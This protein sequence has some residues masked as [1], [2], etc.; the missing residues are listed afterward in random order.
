MLCSTRCKKRIARLSKLVLVLLWSCLPCWADDV[1]VAPIEPGGWQSW[2]ESITLGNERIEVVIVPALGRMTSFSAQGEDNMLRFIEHPETNVWFDA[3]SDRLYPV[4]QVDW[5]KL[6]EGKWPPPSDLDPGAWNARAWR[7][8]NGSQHCVLEV[9][10]GAPLHLACKRSF[11]LAPDQTG[12]RIKQRITRLEA[13]AV[14]VTLWNLTQ[15]N[16]AERVVL[17]LARKSNFGEGIRTVFG[18]TPPE[19]AITFCGN[20]TVVCTTKLLGEVK[21]GTDSLIQWVAGAVGSRMILQQVLTMP[22]DHAYP[23]SGCTVEC[24]VHPG[25][26]YSDLELLGPVSSLPVGHSL[27]NEIRISLHHIDSGLDDCALSKVAKRLLAGEP[28]IA[29]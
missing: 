20:Q 11:H 28:R 8:S 19:V 9:E 29:E 5:N 7:S 10:Y 22:S 12:I 21:L 3:G 27:E 26:G 15:V 1:P 17:P 13:S 6:Q 16:A 14:P 24:Y 2:A 25:L 4:A 23:D 18:N